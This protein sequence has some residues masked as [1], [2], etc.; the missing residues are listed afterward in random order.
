MKVLVHID[1]ASTWRDALSQRLNDLGI[2]DAE[3]MTSQEA[4]HAERTSADYLAAWK[5]DEALLRDCTNLKGIINLGAGVDALLANPA[6]PAGVPIVKL[7]DAGMAELIAD[8][9]RYGLLHFQRDFDRYARQQAERRW[10]PHA[11]VDKQDWPVGVLGLGAIGAKVAQAIAADGFPVLGWSRSP[12]SIEG[13]QCHH[14]EQGLNQLLGQ[15]KTLVLLLPDTPDTQHLINASTLAKL[16][17]GASLINPGRGS[18]IDDTA[19]IEALG[20]HDTPGRLRGALL[21]AFVVE[22]LSN[23]NPLWTHPRVLITPHMAGP[24]PLRDALAQVAESIVALARGK[25]VQVI[26]QRAGY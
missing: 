2:E 9:V 5:P 26:D 17:T 20:A 3:V 12:K 23:D 11:L 22:P 19:L 6:L 21:D 7:R 15:V 1:D 14:G 4:S 25:P 8:Y 18:L 24:T 16:S 13:I 10:Q